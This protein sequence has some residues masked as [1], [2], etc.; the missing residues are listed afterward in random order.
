VFQ[1]TVAPAGAG[2]QLQVR[3][4]MSGLS[5]FLWAKI[6]GGGFRDSAQADLDRLVELVEHQQ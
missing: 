3:I 1:H 2:S 6:I 5:S 4:T